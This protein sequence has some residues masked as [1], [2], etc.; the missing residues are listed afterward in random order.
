MVGFV[1]ILGFNDHK[2]QTDGNAR[3]ESYMGKFLFPI[4][5]FVSFGTDHHSIFL[6][7]TDS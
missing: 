6:Y 1:N 5:D 4:N 3:Y 7:Q 2:Y